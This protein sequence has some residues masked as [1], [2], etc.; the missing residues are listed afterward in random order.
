[1][2][3]ITRKILRDFAKTHGDVGTAIDDWYKVAKSAKWTSS[4]DVQKDFA[5][6]DVVG[7][8]TV[9]NIKGNH[10][11]LI[12]NIQYSRQII[13]IQYVLTHREYD[14]NAWKRNPYY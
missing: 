12:T 8:F 11:R 9:F 4:I 3:I 14:K 13:F 10:Y 6:A 2:R 5:T 7:N 1:M